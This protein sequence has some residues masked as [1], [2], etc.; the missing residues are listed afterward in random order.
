[1]EH[2]NNVI[3]SK[4]SRI[5]KTV[6]KFKEEIALHGH[7]NTK[8]EIIFFEKAIK[9]HEKLANHE[10]END[11]LYL[12]GRIIYFDNVF[13][14]YFIKSNT[15]QRSEK[16]IIN[17]S[18]FIETPTCLK[19]KRCVLNPQKNDNKC[20]RYS[21]TL[22]LYHEQIGKNYCRIPKNKTIH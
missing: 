8:M 14:D 15:D 10:D 21:V 6:K 18:T 22:S 9:F 16:L 2:N 12:N 20:F 3:I 11:I 13:N 1:M 19:L 5:M 4:K 17:N 7:K